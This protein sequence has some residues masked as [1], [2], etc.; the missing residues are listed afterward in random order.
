MCLCHPPRVVEKRFAIY[1]LLCCS[2]QR[3]RIGRPK[4]GRPFLVDRFLVDRSL[5]GPPPGQK[6][7]KIAF[8]SLSKRFE[9]GSP[10]VVIF[11]EG[12]RASLYSK[13]TLESE[14]LNPSVPIQ[15]KDQPNFLRYQSCG[16]QG[17]PSLETPLSASFGVSSVYANGKIKLKETS[18][19]KNQS[20][21][22]KI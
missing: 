1:G 13:R 22:V 12:T 20:T 19:K 14:R 3:R 6:F 15:Q 7:R 17:F 8:E 16:G 4:S 11:N 2:D 9:N 5:V 10:R 18:T 21:V